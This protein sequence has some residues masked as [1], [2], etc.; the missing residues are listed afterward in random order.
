M[1]SGALNVQGELDRIVEAIVYLYTE[2]RRVTKDLARQH[3]LTG[4]QVTVLK[5]LEG[6]GALS[7]SELSNR[8]SA[9]RS[10][11]TG[12]VDRMERDGLVRR[13]RSSRDRRV[14]HLEATPHGQ[15]VA[16]AIPV[17]AMKIFGG[18]LRSLSDADRTELV[19]ILGLL[20]QRVREQVSNQEA[21][22]G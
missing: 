13:Q 7:L 15:E 5:I 16:A 14:I 1:S 3:G 8:M 20:A 9:K 10:T 6:F 11:I 18:A 21:L 12:I 4:P 17:S 2:S 22:G 19:R